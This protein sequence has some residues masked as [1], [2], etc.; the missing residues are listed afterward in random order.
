MAFEILDY[1]LGNAITAG[2]TYKLPTLSHSAVVV[3][4]TYQDVILEVVN[5]EPT[6]EKWSNITDPDYVVKGNVISTM[7]DLEQGKDMELYFRVTGKAP[8]V[9]YATIAIRELGFDYPA[10]PAI[11]TYVQGSY[12]GSG[13]HDISGLV[14][15]GG[16]YT[17]SA[18]AEGQEVDTPRTTQPVINIV[19]VN[20]T[21]V[22]SVM[23]EAQQGSAQFPFVPDS[24]KTVVHLSAPEGV[25]YVLTVQRV[26]FFDPTQDADVTGTWSFSN[27]SGLTMKDGAPILLGQGEN[28]LKIHGTGAGE[29]VIEGGNATELDVAVPVNLQEPITAQDTLTFDN[30]TI[31]EPR[32]SITF[33]GP[34]SVSARIGQSADGCL[35]FGP[36][37]GGGLSIGNNG[38]VGLSNYAY[39]K[40]ANFESAVTM[41]ST[42]TVSGSAT[43]DS[44]IIIP[45]TELAYFGPLVNVFG[46]NEGDFMVN[47][48]PDRKFVTNLV[49]TKNV[50]ANQVAK[51]F[52]ITHTTVERYGCYLQYTANNGYLQLYNKYNLGS[53]SD[54]LVFTMEPEGQ[55]RFRKQV[56]FEGPT[57]ATNA[58]TFGNT[59][60]VAGLATLSGH[61]KIKGHIGLGATDGSAEINFTPV[62]TNQLS[63]LGDQGAHVD[64]YTP[65]KDSA[66]DP[67]EAKDKLLTQGEC[68][69][70]YVLF[71]QTNQVEYNGIA[72]KNPGTIYHTTDTKIFYIG[73]KRFT[74]LATPLLDDSIVGYSD[75][76]SQTADFGTKKASVAITTSGGNL[77]LSG[78][79]FNGYGDNNRDVMTVS[80]VLDL[81]KIDTPGAFTALFNAKGG[82]TSW[83]AGLNTNRT[84]QGLWDNAAYGGGP[85][86]PALG[87]EGTLTISVVTGELGTRIYLGDSDTH[88][89]TSSLR[90][91]G[92]NLTQILMDAGLANA[93][94]QLYVHDST[95]SQAQIGQLMA[96]IASVV[97][98]NSSRTASKTQAGESED[99]LDDE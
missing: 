70:R 65:P 21:R 92:A 27:V 84:L 25:K 68:D 51:L 90:F 89:T 55:L 38:A 47:G 41:G 75:F 96:E 11:A 34:N 88:R 46:T 31:S 16:V 9:Q 66:G 62:A 18:V 67:L 23:R 95:L 17:L 63:V 12:V 24:D 13:Y 42:I 69:A 74:P 81:S 73:D 7:L 19:G 83:G 79:T 60:T 5:N 61:A 80:M 2:V 45:S 3:S 44:G 37:T 91:S 78:T 8:A 56:T 85:I 43:F 53:P 76:A 71:V 30:T 57:S 36:T 72:V 22:I 39:L 97:F 52:D 49:Y 1:Q 77:V 29:A 15:P 26:N 33:N 40:G 99:L 10:P 14:S 6:D 86:T 32:N 64:I 54:N 94:E 87:T 50:A 48:V 4:S 35:H 20:G 93:V 82:T 58:F 59:I 28:A 98:E